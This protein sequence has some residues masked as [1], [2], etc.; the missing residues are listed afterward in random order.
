MENQAQLNTGR[1]EGHTMSVVKGWCPDAHRP[2]L[3]GDGLLV[4]IR[5]RLG[6]LTIKQVLELCEISL[7]HGNGAIDLTSRANIQI[8][9]IRKTNYRKLLDR[10][11]TF[12]LLDKDSNTESRRNI[13]TTP[14]WKSGDITDV[15]HSEISKCLSDLPNLPSKIGIALDTGLVP[16]LGTASADFRFEFNSSR[17]LMLRADGATHGRAIELD[18]APEALIQMAK[19]FQESG[20]IQAGR[21]AR[22]LVTKNLPKEWQ[23][24]PAQPQAKAL[25]PGPAPSP[26]KGYFVGVPFGSLDAKAFT[27]LILQAKTTAIRCTPWRLILLE[28]VEEIDNAYDFIT[29]P[30]DPILKVHACPGAPACSSATVETRAVARLLASKNLAGLHLSGCAKG[31]AH[32]HLSHTTLVGQNGAYNLVEGGH[33]WD[34]PSQ[35]GLSA[36]DLQKLLD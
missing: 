15:L 20:G 14:L 21:M 6:R 8:R 1:T 28:G 16:M 5:P 22:H 11:A 26:H 36:S 4:R 7:T 19:W 23:S 35:Q 29:D 9:G 17:V 27:S 25:K 34:Q 12:D 30:N 33:P 31:C 32:P 3:S 10:L 18:N 13:L 2:M 24:H